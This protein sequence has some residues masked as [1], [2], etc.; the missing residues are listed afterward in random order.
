MDCTLIVYAP[1]TAQSDAGWVDRLPSHL[2][3]RSR[4]GLKK[5]LTL[6]G[7][8]SSVHIALL[9]PQDCD[10]LEELAKLA[11]D[12]TGWR[13]LIELPDDRKESIHVAKPLSP[14]YFSFRGDNPE[15]LGAIIEKMVQLEAGGNS[16]R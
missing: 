5:A 14:R 13:V 15:Y 6:M 12:F 8:D 1:V 11:E 9:L 3:V 7:R 16:R 10:D 2:T 4:E